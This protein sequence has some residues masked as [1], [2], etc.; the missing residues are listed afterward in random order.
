MRI[1]NKDYNSKAIFLL[2]FSQK[3]KK[4]KSWKNQ[5]T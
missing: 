2:F 1:L 3:N 5:D 4:K